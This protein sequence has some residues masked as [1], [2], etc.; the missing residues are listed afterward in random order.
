LARLTLALVVGF[1]GCATT[2]RRVPTAAD[3][4]IATERLGGVVDDYWRYLRVSRPELVARTNDVITALPDP[5]QD[6]AK[7]DAQL[8]RAVLSALD[9]ID[10][11]ALRED[12]Y[13]TWATLRWEMEAMSGWAA[14]HWTNVFHFTPGLSVLDR[15]SEI[16]SAREINDTGS[17][18]G[19]TGL[20][21][22]VSAVVASL[23]AEY[24]ERIGRGIR[25][26]RTQ[27]LRA[28]EYLRSLIAPAVASPF[29]VPS[30]FRASSDTAWHTQFTRSV[31][32]V[33]TQQVNP[34]LNSLATFLE[35]EQAAATDTI[36]MYR[37]PGGAAHYAALLRY[38]STLDI[39][40]TDAHAIGLREVVR[41]AAL[42]AAAR[43]DAGLPVNRDSLRAVLK[44]D[45]AFVFDER[46]SLPERSAQ[47]FENVA[48]EM[49]PHFRQVPAM[50]LSIGVMPA[51]TY[52]SPLTKYVP[53]EFARPS[54]MYLLNIEQ[55]VP[56]SA[57]LLPGLVIGDLMPGLHLQ[58]GSQLENPTLPMF[59]RLGSH[60]GFVEGWQVYALGAADSL[61]TTLVP[62]QRFSLRLRELAAACGL[63]VDTGI[64]ALGWTREDAM[65]FLRGYLPYDDDDLERDFIFAAVESPATLTGGALG[66]RELRGL[67]HWAARE[68]GDRFTLAAFH[69]EVL[70]VGSVPLPVLGAHL[71]R[72]LWDLNHP[73]PPAAGVRR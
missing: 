59:R 66:A 42:A 34:A 16:L 39:T 24:E 29:G 26:S 6:R 15:T 71:E 22:S 63:V 56:R 49:E 28:V 17:A 55:L 2:M 73:A 53:A 12:D 70:R 13:V 58:Q 51:P 31:E 69:Q 48:K 47:L 32:D 54:A 72:W 41:I 30:T 27:G 67:R 19:F 36:G 3:T 7:K 62:W 38:H 60:D 45:S 64:N 5:T 33:I 8:A 14:F 10:V 20:V 25:L 43:R 37:L 46:S 65:T 9:E 1:E 35:R 44:Q 4:V 11:N 23:R 21:S 57:L 52:M 68:S 61:S 40:P 18:Q 50:G